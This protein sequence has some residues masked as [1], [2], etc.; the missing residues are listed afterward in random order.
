MAAVSPAVQAV[1]RL[2]R[3]LTSV[4]AEDADGLLDELTSLGLIP[5]EDYMNQYYDKSPGDKARQLLHA[6]LKG[7]DQACAKF[8]S[9]LNNMIMR[10]PKLSCLES[11]RKYFDELL[12]SLDM[13]IYANGVLT[14]K[15]VLEIGK[16]SLEQISLHRL[17]DVPWYLIHNFM[18]LNVNARKSQPEQSGTDME[19]LETDLETL[20]FSLD[21]ETGPELIHPLDVLCV[22]LH[23]ANSFL[24]QEIVSK[25]SMCQ[26]AIPLL[27]PST[28]GP[29]CTFMIWAMRDV[30]KKWR[31][32][33]LK[34]T[35]GFMEDN[36]VNIALPFYS[37]VRLQNCSISKSAIINQLLAP[38]QQH[39]DYFL[40]RNMEGGN[41]SRKI[42]DGLVEMSSYFPSG[43]DNTDIFTDP[44]A[45]LNLRGDIVS[46]WTQ[47]SF[48]TQISSVVF[49]FADSITETEYLLL[50]SL[51]NSK[52]KYVIICSV[53][54][55]PEGITL[56]YV[57]KL[58]PVLNPQLLVK[59]HKINDATLV[60]KVQTIMRSSKNTFL[61]L[62]EMTEK[63][64]ELGIHID[65]NSKE[66]QMAKRTALNITAEITNVESYK[67][68]TMKL[69]G[70]LW[71]ELARIDVEMCRMKNQG[72]QNC[73]TYK[74]KLNK[75]R[76]ELLEKQNKHSLPNGIGQFISAMISL[77]PLERHFFLKWIKIL[78]D[79][80]ARKNLVSLQEEYQKMCSTEST[81]RKKMK[82]LDQKMSDSS[83]GPEHFVRELGQF[84]EAES[85]MVKENNLKPDERKFHKLPEVAADLLLDGFPLELMDGD[86]SNI[87]L[88]W[89]KDILATLDKKAGGQ[90]RV[91]VITVL[92]VQSTGKSTLLN[93]MF[94]LQ[95]P[96]AN[97]RCTRGAF[98]T[99]IKVKQ[100]F[101]DVL[102]CNFILVI[103]TEGLKAPE[104]ASLDES[105]E[106]DN[107]L[108]TL[109]VGLSD[110]T[111][112]N[113]AMENTAEMKDILQIVVH[114][115]LRMQTT[116][117]K[118]NCQFI[119]QN[120]GDVSAH[121]KNMRD[122]A[123]LSE[124]LNEITKIAAK[125]EKKTEVTTF[126]DVMVHEKETHTWYIPSL[127]LGVPPM[128]SVNV[129]Y[130]ETISQL[131]RH[132]L[133]FMRDHSSTPQTLH[134]FSEWLMSLWKSVMYE[135][136]IF[137]FRN[138]LVAEA[139]EKLSIKY[140][141][142]RWNF[143]KGMHSWIAEGENE[144]RNEKLDGLQTVH[145][146]LKEDMHNKLCS[147]VTLMRESLEQYFK[148]GPEHTNLIE[149]YKEEFLR[150]ATHVRNEHERNLS[151]RLEEAVSI[152]KGK[153][154][155]LSI[156]ESFLQTI[157]A[158][159]T[160][161]LD[162]YKDNKLNLD[163]KAIKV[164]FEEMWNET[165]SGLQLSYIRRQDI[166]QNIFTQ[167]R[168]D[169]VNSVSAV[170]EKLNTIK[171][172][173]AV[174]EMPFTIQESYFSTPWYENL[175]KN[176]TYLK[177]V[178]QKCEHLFN[179]L[180]SKCTSY[181]MQKISTKED[182]HETYCQ[183]LLL[184]IN[185]DPL[186]KD[187]QM[188]HTTPLFNLDVKLIILGKAALMFQKM[189]EDFIKD[190]DPRLS[191]EQL[192]PQYL[193]TFENI[194][195]MKDEC[196]DR[197]KDFCEKC[198]KPAITEFV[199][200]NLG[201]EMV[202]DILRSLDSKQY[203]SRAFFQY[204]LL[205]KLLEDKNFNLYIEYIRKYE[206]F[207]RTFINNNIQEK[208]KRR[209]SLESVQNKVFR[210][211]IGRV[212]QALQDSNIVEC[213]DVPLFL[214]KFCDMLKKEL[215]IS[216]SA[217][218][219]I[220]FQNKASVRQFITDI[221]KFLLSTEMEIKEELNSLSVQSLLTKVTLKP[222]DE[223]FRKVIGCGKQCPF[224]NVPCEAGG[225]GHT[226]HFASIHRPQ[227]LAGIRSTKKQILYHSLCSTDV[228]GNGSFRNSDTD[229]QP[230]PNKDYRKVYPDWSIQPDPSISASDYWKFV[231]KEYND[232]FAKH[233][234]AGAARLP[235]EWKALTEQ[236]ALCSLQEIFNTT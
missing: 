114:A 29:D 180:Q 117:K 128:A 11:R 188:L 148:S 169:M 65:E 205:K 146:R 3:R 159:V 177:E 121:V 108:A 150:N 58:N 186:Q 195:Q 48:L 140:S 4:F 64:S 142:L 156:Q 115:F 167:L 30:V 127:W 144:I 171:D 135:T 67:K 164:K 152:R 170:K 202:D 2:Q 33:S 6:V 120:V 1:C 151:H 90:C 129:G 27:L 98:M 91:R 174:Q 206:T 228:I 124:E 94:G 189:H 52:A 75:Q 31:P 113:M 225:D 161:L 230:C 55:N 86:A 111:I 197:A 22:V 157:E 35:K 37:F 211:V 97:G 221:E 82:N 138:S 85:F 39:Y 59:N 119:H 28:D 93:T 20:D 222:Q 231:F 73:E 184:T 185:E 173:S 160:S 79:S 14:R 110:I 50:S 112:I 106:H 153:A 62:E 32:Q 77:N 223:L 183:E 89:I 63:A 57:K 72:D 209:Q 25:M 218:K 34:E 158:K 71:K 96:V 147:E 212:V 132:L 56:E 215:V 178:E 81:D 232:E 234:K 149:R 213:S 21:S 163:N 130:S 136:F 36:L 13:K 92:G 141:E 217:L 154:A 226:E 233:H 103:D 104:L 229:W 139:Y 40:H 69:Q 179:A 134:G 200:K 193:S 80:L 133:E 227:G 54:S 201:K 168:N 8:L 214:D 46:N 87:P 187:L 143:D 42:S 12:S 100:D 236:N 126:T 162:H 7:G 216:Q 18:S 88:Q 15:E 84:Y 123:K 207:V 68:E 102:K 235:E 66:C 190:N 19:N 44:L 41:L 137:S 199:Y 78:L 210:Q 43:Q 116:G 16:D 49:I 23:C 182:Y 145:E 83:L 122:R 10:F 131:K 224:C 107:Q 61:K 9:H 53:L 203:S 74:A 198:L 70:D 155:I 101:Q 172:L 99:L 51:Q 105:Y 166:P 26:F 219:V 95:F 191:L 45:V 109:V 47:F 38:G 165:L 204:T 5:L 181:I 192:K 118:P 175:A 17:Q 24:Q 125:M 60:K 76:A 194:F 208:Y 196:Q 220:T 176:I